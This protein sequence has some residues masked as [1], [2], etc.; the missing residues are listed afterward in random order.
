MIH[1][2]F[3][4]KMKNDENQEKN[5]DEVNN[6]IN[7]ED[8]GSRFVYVHPTETVHSGGIKRQR[9]IHQIKNKE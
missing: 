9:R 2:L 7:S 4:V 3:S 8:Y 5:I 1:F 6:I